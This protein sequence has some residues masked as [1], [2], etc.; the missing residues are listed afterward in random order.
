MYL[1]HRSFHL[2]AK[3]F[4][5]KGVCLEF[6]VGGGD[7]Y[8]Y[9]VQQITT[10]YP[11]LELIGFD[12]W[13][14]LPKE[15]PGV[16]CPERHEEKQLTFSKQQVLSCIPP[17]DSRF[18]LVDGFFENSLTAKLQKSVG[19]IIFINIDVDIH[20][21]TLEVLAFVKPLLQPG[22][23]L[24]WDDWKDPADDNSTPWGEHLAWEEWYE[25]QIDIE[26]ETL[27][28]NSVNQRSMLVTKANG[29]ELSK[30]R[31]VEIRKICVSI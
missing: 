15:T 3:V 16:W 25:N 31:Q 23:I 7:T 24:Y 26:V 6:G 20:S 28:V 18:K 1:F 30:E 4:Q 12:S 21:S 5:G 8:S 10:R 29:G 14:G 22:T 17:A 27:E 2:A 11:G 19:P 13:Q 9:Q